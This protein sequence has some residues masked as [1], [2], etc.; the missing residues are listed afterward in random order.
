MKHEIKYNSIQAVVGDFGLYSN[1]SKWP[2]PYNKYNAF[3]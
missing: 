3:N 1:E 2:F